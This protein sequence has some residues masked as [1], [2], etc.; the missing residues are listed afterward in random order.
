MDV[1]DKINKAVKE[2]TTETPTLLKQ[3][4]ILN[5]LSAKLLK[6]MQDI[7]KL[8]KDRKVRQLMQEEEKSLKGIVKALEKK[9]KI[10][11]EIVSDYKLNKKIITRDKD[12]LKNMEAK[13]KAA[14]KSGK[15]QKNV[16]DTLM[17]TRDEHAANIKL[18]EISNQTLY[19]SLDWMERILGGASRLGKVFNGAL[20]AVT[21]FITPFKI[22]GKIL[23]TGYDLAKKLV[24]PFINLSKRVLG[25]VLNKFFELEKATGDLSS[26]M[27]LTTQQMEQMR[28][29]VSVAAADAVILGASI[30]DV[31]NAQ[32]TFANETGRNVLLTRE[33]LEAVIKIGKGTALGVENASQLVS[34]ME[35]FGIET[36]NAMNYIEKTQMKLQ[37]VGLN[38]QKVLSTFKGLVDT[39]ALFTGSLQQ[40]TKDL[41][42]ISKLSARYRADL[43]GIVKLSDQL[44]NP[45]GAIELAA[46][47]K[48][49]GGNFASMAD[50]FKL[51]YQAQ[52]DIAGLTQTFVDATAASAKF[53]SV[54]GEFEIPPKQRGILNA[55]AQA[56]GQSADDLAKMAIQSAKFAK[57]SAAMEHSGFAFTNQLKEYVENIATFKDGKAF[58]NVKEGIE[59]V[60]VEV[61]KL[62]QTQ[63]NQI[64][65]QQK[66]AQGLEAGARNRMTIMEKI[67]AIGD[68]FFTRIGGSI[69]RVL[70][71]DQFRNMIDT[72]MTRSKEFIEYIGANLDVMMDPNGVLM[73]FINGTSNTISNVLDTAAQILQGQGF[74]GL[75]DYIKDQF[76]GVVIPFLTTTFEDIFEKVIAKIKGFVLGAGIGAIGGALIGSLLG[77]VGTVIGAKIG[78]TL[79]AGAGVAM[80][81]GRIGN[82]ESAYVQ[83]AKG[84]VNV[85]KF[86]K[87][88]ALYA[89]NESQAGAKTTSS[90]INN[91]YNMPPTVTIRVEG[92]G[93]HTVT[94]QEIIAALAT[95]YQ[96]VANK[97]TKIAATENSTGQQGK[98]SSM[99][100]VTPL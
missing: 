18:Q 28:R 42:D 14:Q 62:N 89:I 12:E 21:G 8:K 47:L 35:L 31:A 32:K 81:D 34:V 60:A 57:A 6:N 71:S 61:S 17:K 51:M 77:P 66:V 50:P 26:D 38:S 72:I 23:S 9:H 25:T 100:P 37:V 70:E 78:A 24:A 41:M 90:T 48:I 49:L 15:L 39:S 10:S 69:L 96:D 52:N 88:D 36:E 2:L 33:Q 3:Q 59:M 19:D 73:T 93:T 92:G 43:S 64:I 16:L 54:T 22:V 76:T 63:Y 65:A 5:D 84:A 1:F 85:E 46:Q 91:N 40:G 45:E 58:V 13:I 4:D 83:T 44:F 86:A 68:T 30:E 87:G 29:A 79:G 27:S 82:V 98:R 94:R 95:N 7:N 97:S 56:T 11:K 55:V 20:A 67:R 80:A 99:V 53:N 75:G 74:S